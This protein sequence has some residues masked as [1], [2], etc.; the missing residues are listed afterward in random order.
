MRLLFCRA[1]DMTVKEAISPCVIQMPVETTYVRHFVKCRNKMFPARFS[2][3]K[4]L[5][6]KIK[7]KK[8]NSDYVQS[9]IPGIGGAV[10]CHFSRIEI[11]PDALRKIIYS[12]GADVINVYF[13]TY[14]FICEKKNVYL[15]ELDK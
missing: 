6:S 10:S 2:V 13:I 4:S 14:P 15:F 8:N 7:A 3:L 12:T 9:L 5:L 11:H 1:Y